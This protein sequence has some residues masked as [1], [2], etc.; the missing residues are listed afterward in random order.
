MD[1]PGHL[2]LKHTRGFQYDQN[3][4]NDKKKGNDADHLIHCFH[5]DIDTI[6][7]GFLFVLDCLGKETQFLFPLLQFFLPLFQRFFT[8]LEFSFFRIN[9]NFYRI[10][11]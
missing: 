11:T 5:A 2:Q 8:L 4:H 1:N 7:P 10:K 6:I 3:N 9:S